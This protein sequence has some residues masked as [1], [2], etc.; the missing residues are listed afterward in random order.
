MYK[1]TLQQ[2]LFKIFKWLIFK[3]KIIKICSLKLSEYIFNVKK[4]YIGHF[5]KR[6]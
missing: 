3:N 5:F 2:F 4:K 1:I 6:K